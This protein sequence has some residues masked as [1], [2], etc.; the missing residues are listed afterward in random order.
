MKKV[1]ILLIHLLIVI[2][3]VGCQLLGLS[4]NRK[5]VA[6]AGE[7]LTITVGDTAQLNGSESSDADG[8]SLVFLWNI[9]SAPNGS[10]A[11][12][13][14]TTIANPVLTPDVSG[15]F[16]IELVVNDGR[17]DSDKDQIII[18]VSEKNGFELTILHTNDHH[19]RPLAFYDYPAG[20]QGGLP[21]QATYVNRHREEH[22]N[23]LLLGAGD[24]NTGRPESTFFNAEPDIIGFNYIGYDAIVM[25]SHEFD[26]SRAV[27]QEQILQSDFPWLCA[28]VT[29]NG[30]YLDNVLPY[31]IKEFDGFKV[32]IMGLLTTT[33]ANTAYP[34]H[35]AGL[36]FSDEV[37]VANQIVSELE[38]QVDL[39][40]ALVHLGL[41]DSNQK[42]SRKLAQE[43][44][45]IDLIVDGYTH[46]LIDEPI[47][48]NGIPIVQAR[49][50]G[51]YVGNSRLKFKDGVITSFDWQ[52]DPINVQYRTTDD[53]GNYIYH[54]V[55]EEIAED[56][57]LI[58]MLNPF[59]EEVDNILGEVIGEA[60]G[61]FSNDSTRYVETALGNL[62]ADSQ[63]WFF[64]ERGMEVDFAF[65]NGGGI[66]STLGAGDITKMDIYNVLPFDN[67]ITYLSLTGLE[68]ISLF[69][70]AAT[71][72]G[73][74][75]M[76]Q[77]SEN[78]K[79]IFDVNNQTVSDLVIN[80]LS[81]DN[82][83]I[84]NIVVNS[85][86]AAGGDGYDI[87]TYATNYYD[88]AVMQRDAL[89]DYI[90]YLGGI[91]TPITNERI[92]IPAGWR[93]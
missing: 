30:E 69:E 52:L 33:T 86:L 28:N 54:Y 82:T 42:G 13:S 79:V 78:V 46:T 81:V 58:A 77:V 64:T 27:I 57:T 74:G 71:K 76:S 75:G 6:N 37:I 43:V 7:D 18:S 85:Y 16:I 41:Y 55:T 35:V 92:I 8:D 60:T 56:E 62:V 10:T 53:L 91:I 49:H 14:D 20:N 50:W 93:V 44:P 63:I 72:L 83:R 25:G 2:I 5:P 12:L 59:M 90:L 45:G 26:N 67:S 29:E 70:L 48:E 34:D 68:V 3:I 17:D 40:I 15:E 21:A 32:G 38:D 73:T 9:T 11:V 84:Y 23:V 89:I 24:F 39:I 51:L 61:D 19:G 36:T 1:I 87:F 65:Q 22:N 66:R 88:S 47:I 4:K 80:G 31:T